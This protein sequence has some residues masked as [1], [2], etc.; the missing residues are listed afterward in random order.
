LECSETNMVSSG[1]LTS[2]QNIKDKP[3]DEKQQPLRS[4][5]ELNPFNLIPLYRH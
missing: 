5:E 4:G 2:T 3:T 1:W